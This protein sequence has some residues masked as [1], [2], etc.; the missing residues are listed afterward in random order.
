MT[1]YEHLQ[2][3]SQR[4]RPMGDELRSISRTQAFGPQMQ[5]FPHV[6]RLPQPRTIID[7]DDDP[8]PTAA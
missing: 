5:R 2:S 6:A 4:E 7:N 8:G 1:S 3:I